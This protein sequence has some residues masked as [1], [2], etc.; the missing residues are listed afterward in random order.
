LASRVTVD[1]DT[2]LALALAVVGGSTTPL[3][4]LNGDFIVVAASASFFDAFE[5]D[6]AEVAA[7]SLFE[8]RSGEWNVP[9]LRALLKATADGSAQV[10]AYEMDLQGD[11]AGPRRLVISARKLDYGDPEHVRLLMSI[12]DVTDARLADKLKDDLLREKAILLQ[13]IQHRVANSLQIIA[14]V[15]LQSAR[16]VQSEEARGYLTDAHS[17]VMSV[18]TLQKQLAASRL[19]D[20]ELRGYFRQ[21]CESIAASMIRDPGQLSLEV[22]VD[23]SLVRAEVSVSLGLVVTELVINA[24]KHAFPGGRPGRMVVRYHSQGPNWNLSVTD[25]GVGMPKDAASAV[26]GLGTSIVAALASQL[27]ARVQ[28]ND[29]RP[30]TTVSLVHGEWAFDEPKLQGGPRNSAT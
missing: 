20:V 14:S 11:R 8:L 23:D 24:L 16:R 15:I 21:L 9:Q 7:R 17:R 27:R 22:D 10:E 28:V 4:L 13:E 29:A 26:P 1:P 3:V 12:A 2:G 6:P 30:G 19:G 5:V 18:A 25:D